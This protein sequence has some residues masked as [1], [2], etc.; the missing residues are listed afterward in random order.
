MMTKSKSRYRDARG[1]EVDE[2]EAVDRGVLRDGFSLVTSL[3]MADSLTPLQRSVAGHGMRVTD[4]SGDP[5][6]M[7]RP[8]PRYVADAAMRNAKEAAYAEYLHDAT[9]AWRGGDTREYPIEAEGTVCTVKG[10]AFRSHFGAPGHVCGGLCVP[11]EMRDAATRDSGQ[12]LTLDQLKNW[13]QKNMGRAYQQYD[14]EL[15][16][17]WRTP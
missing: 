12:N 14:E 1:V 2:D 7:H 15:R 13:H 6:G 11:D 17:A 4:G 10:P 16:N 9:N 8:G 5:S 3:A